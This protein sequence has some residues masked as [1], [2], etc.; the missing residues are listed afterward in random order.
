MDMRAVDATLAALKRA[1]VNAIFGLPGGP[2][3]PLFDALHDDPDIRTFLVRHEQGAGHMAEGYA[4]VTGRAGVCTATSGPG[5]TNL[6]TPI[7][8]AT[9]TRCRWWRSPA[10]WAP[11]GSAPTPSRRPTSS[12]SP[13][14]W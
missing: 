8:D 7:T 4:K 5:A 6:V 9:W 14:R 12:A 13:C 1:G 10:R 11:P 2:V 3:I